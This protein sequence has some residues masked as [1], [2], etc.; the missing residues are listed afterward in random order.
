MTDLHERIAAA[1]AEKRAEFQM[2]EGPLAGWGLA[3]CDHADKVLARH[4]PRESS[5]WSSHHRDSDHYE[6]DPR[7]TEAECIDEF[8]LCNG[9]GTTWLD[10]GKVRCGEVR[11]L[12]DLWLGEGWQS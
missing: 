2:M 7:C 3:A 12:A 1:V 4:Y 9:C 10:D 11:D 8:V 6:G 5:S